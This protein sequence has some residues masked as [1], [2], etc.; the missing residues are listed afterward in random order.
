ML[1]ASNLGRGCSLSVS[2]GGR[3]VRAIKQAGQD[4]SLRLDR[5]GFR[6]LH[7]QLRPLSTSYSS[8]RPLG[9]TPHSHQSTTRSFRCSSPLWRALSTQPPLPPKPDSS[10]VSSPPRLQRALTSRTRLRILKRLASL[11]IPFPTRSP[12]L[13]SSHVRSWG[14]K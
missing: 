7:F 3:S 9:Y 11:R 12:L 1:L 5:P 13:V 4:L 2:P 14:I 10:Q 8:P 6:P